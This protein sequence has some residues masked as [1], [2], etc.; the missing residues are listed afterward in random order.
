MPYYYING[1]IVHQPDMGEIAGQQINESMDKFMDIIQKNRER[2]KDEEQMIRMLMLEKQMIAD[3][4]KEAFARQQQSYGMGNIESGA[5]EDVTDAKMALS[6][7]PDQQVANPAKAIRYQTT[8]DYMGTGRNVIG[9]QELRRG[10]GIQAQQNIAPLLSI[11]KN[12]NASDQE[13]NSAIQASL[14]GSLSDNPQNIA[15]VL[16]TIVDMR[17]QQQDERTVTGTEHLAG[18][19]GGYFEP[20]KMSEESTLSQFAPALKEQAGDT[21]S[22]L[23]GYLATN[24][25]TAVP[26]WM[27]KGYDY[28]TKGREV[29]KVNVMVPTPERIKL[30]SGENA[31]SKQS[32]ASLKKAI[33][34]AR[35]NGT[36]PDLFVKLGKKGWFREDVFKAMAE[37]GID[38]SEAV[39]TK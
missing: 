19:T 23:G 27:K 26:Y 12:P 5:V 29:P 8:P 34:S 9:Q 6:V 25:V 38:K 33:L 17:K 39:R 37:L 24:P 32:Y 11:L 28:L 36:I 18:E 30:S 4:E 3:R 35:E 10:Q 15:Q 13:V 7:S 20:S 31:L 16:K 1:Q 2:K 22:V 21:S 14:V